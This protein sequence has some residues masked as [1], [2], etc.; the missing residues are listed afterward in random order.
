MKS[1]LLSKEMLCPYIDESLK[2]HGSPW[3]LR[4]ANTSSGGE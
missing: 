4:I 2:L 1:L 3:K